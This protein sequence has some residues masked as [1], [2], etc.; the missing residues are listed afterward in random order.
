MDGD[1]TKVYSY[2]MPPS[3]NAD[4]STL[5]V[6]G[7]EVSGF[8]FD[9]TS[10][11]IDVGA[12]VRQVTVS[13]EVRQLKASIASITPADAN[14]TI[15][16]HQVDVNEG[17]NSLVVTAT[18]QDG[19]TKSYT[20][21]VQG[22]GVVLS[23]SPLVV[24]EGNVA[25]NSYTVKLSHVPTGAVTVTITGHTGT[26]LALDKTSLTFTTA[27]WNIDQTVTVTAAADADAVD[28]AATLTH[29]AS[30]GGFDDR[31]I[32]LAVRVEDDEKAA[33]ST[34][35]VSPK[36]IIGFNSDRRDYAVG[37]ASTADP[38]RRSSP[39]HRQHFRRNVQQHRRRF[40]VADGHQVESVLP[41]PTPS[42]SRSPAR[43]GTSPGNTPLG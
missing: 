24:P 33:L 39:L 16:G 9:T 18:A 4:L 30:G 12:A 31:S 38:A 29:T 36:D 35:T 32:D 34:F 23:E 40:G 5:A 22:S 43:T 13:A 10:Y 25:G 28:D 41:A 17:E 20:I 3:S 42:P 26:D 19:T 7:A 8:D 15:D 1:Q 2:N 14:T 11:V 37:M 6:D 27:N 21:T